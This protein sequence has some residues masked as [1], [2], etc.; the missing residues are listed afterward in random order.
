MLKYSATLNFGD[1]LWKMKAKLALNGSD[2][3]KA[4]RNLWC[5]G[6]PDNQSQCDEN[7]SISQKSKTWVHIPS[8][9]EC[10][11]LIRYPKDRYLSKIEFQER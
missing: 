3:K 1:K 7:L 11:Q 10:Q 2:K 8:M 9:Y 4:P 6:M 5:L